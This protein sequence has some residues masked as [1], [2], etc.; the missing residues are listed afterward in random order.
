[1]LLNISPQLEQFVKREVAN[2]RF[3]RQSDVVE[4][5]LCFGLA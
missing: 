2:S 3:A 4:I 5:K 1:M